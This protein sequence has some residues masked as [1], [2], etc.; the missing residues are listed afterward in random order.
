MR[1]M[2]NGKVGIGTTAPGWQFVVQGA[3]SGSGLQDG[4]VMIRSTT[5]ANPSGLMFINS[6]N[7]ASYN[8]LGSIQGIIESGNAKGALR[9]ITRNSDGNNTDVDERM[10][11]TSAGNVGIG[12]ASPIDSKLVIVETPATIVSGNAINGSTMKGLKLRTNANGDESV[13]VWFGTNGSHWSGISGQRKNSSSTWG[14]TLSF[15][16]HEDATNDLTYARERMLIDS[17]GRV[18]IPGDLAV[19]E[20]HHSST[21]SASSGATSSF[22]A[23]A[24]DW[25]DV[26]VVPYGRQIAT[27]KLFW[28]GLSA[29]GSAHHGN[30]EFDIQSHYGTSYYYGWDS[31]INLKNSSAHNS[32]F[33]SEARII[34][35]NGSGAT[36]YFQVKFGVAVSTGLFR[37]YATFLDEQCTI[38][39]VNPVV[40]NSR[41]GTTIAEVLLDNRPSFATSRDLNVT[42]MVRAQGHPAFRAAGT[43]SWN[44]LSGNVVA[45]FNVA[46]VNT[47]G[48]YSASNYR[49]TAPVAGNYYFA[50]H[51][52]NDNN[53]SN[54]IVP[55]LNGTALTGG[56]GDSIVAFNASGVSGNLT[57]SAQVVLALAKN[58][59]VDLACR[60]NHSSRIYMP[61]SQFSG[62]L[63]G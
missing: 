35:P 20:I 15:Y 53:Y 38:S 41:T 43:N 25:I 33:I 27:I 7:T 2:A 58:D 8:D 47:G 60:G 37:T 57:I 14:T 61:H 26:A 40:N 45:P 55:R 32:F 18:T 17:E 52:Y 19:G 22:S 11:I 49:F 28:D 30:M 36:G 16:T 48:H 1:I 62:Y 59:Y 46:M 50:W 42:G 12:L 6:G 4:H 5:T 44:T 23:S 3:G 63:I 13:G 21:R 9:F 31:S 51:T 24:G 34:T 10:R 54:A 39:P 56:G 29:P